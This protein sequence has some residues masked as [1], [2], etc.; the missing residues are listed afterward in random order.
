MSIF[1]DDVTDTTMARLRGNKPIKVHMPPDT[2]DQSERLY[3]GTL[4]GTV[5]EPDVS[6]FKIVEYATW[7]RAR[8]CC[9]EYGLN[10]YEDIQKV[11]YDPPPLTP[12]RT[13]FYSVRIPYQ[14]YRPVGEEKTKEWLKFAAKLKSRRKQIESEGGYWIPAYLSTAGHKEWQSYEFPENSED[15][16][17]TLK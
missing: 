11:P 9:E 10:P 5:W 14:S 7:K 17:E 3:L 6:R 12:S 2:S 1:D 8:E 15:L 16:V 13:H 4:P